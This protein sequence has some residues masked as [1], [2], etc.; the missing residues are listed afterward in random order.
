M[1]ELR[2]RACHVSG[3]FVAKDNVAAGDLAQPSPRP[4]GRASTTTASRHP[5]AT[6]AQEKIKVEVRLPA[7][8]ALHRRARPERAP[9]RRAVRPRH[10]RAG[11]P[12]QRAEWRGARP[13]SE[14]DGKVLPTL[15]LNVAH[16][17][18][19]DEIAGFC[20]GKRPCWSSRRARPTSSSRRSAQILRKADMRHQALR[21]GRA[22]D[23][24]RVH[25][26]RWSTEGLLKFFAQL[27]QRHRS[28]RAARA[29]RGRRAPAA[30]RSTRPLG[31]PLPLAAA[32]L[33]H[34]LPGAAGL[35]GHE[36]AA[37]REM[38]P[39]HVSSRHRLPFVCD[40]RA[41]QPGQFDPGLRH[42]AGVRRRGG[43][44]HAAKRPISVMGD[45]GFWHNGL[46]TRRR[47]RRCSTSGDRVLVVM[48]QRLLQRH[49]PAGHPLQHGGNRRPRREASTSRRR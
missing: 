4:S 29:L 38:G 10:H 8:A 40:L 31:A 43:A 45:G 13:A 5:P 34:R 2:I 17:L 18:V 46:I 25:R 9:A 39:V 33:L 26:R 6:Y 27:G 7:A 19:P 35:L 1:L 44:G 11:R 47:R 20:A 12:H 41:V 28:R 3:S 15:V 49:R 22:A 42:V 14:V 32:G 16:P 21:Q 23:G 36:A 48:Q 24:G 30:P 37:Q